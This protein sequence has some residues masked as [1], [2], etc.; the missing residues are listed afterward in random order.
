MTTLFISDLHLEE[1]RPATTRAFLQFLREDAAAAESLYVL[2]DLFE[3]WVGDDDDAELAETVR[4]ALRQLT[5]GG[6]ALYFMHGNRDF[7]LGERFAA[8]TGGR[9][10]NDPTVIDLY[11]E[12]TLLLHGDSL[13][14]AD[15]AY[16]Q[17]RT[18]VRSPEWQRQALSQSL[19]ARRE[20][21]QQ[22][23]TASAEANSNKA[24]DIMDVTPEEVVEALRRHDCRRMIHGHT[25]RP[26]THRLTVDGEPAERIVLGDWDTHRWVLRV[27]ERGYSLEKGPIV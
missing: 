23:R 10:L 11:G 9:M 5:D 20:I 4:S 19:A 7:L 18:Q 14:T 16:Q 27:D 26:A 22:M 6:T 2:G 21:A 1:K 25:H 13:C 17:L 3:A 8:D 15:T 12:P 24:E